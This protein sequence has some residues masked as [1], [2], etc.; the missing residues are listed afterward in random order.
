MKICLNALAAVFL[1]LFSAL[2][3]W[4]QEMDKEIVIENDTLPYLR[5]HE[6]IVDF[7][8]V[9][10]GDTVAQRY[11]FTNTGVE[12]LIIYRALTTCGCTAS[13]YTK[14]KVMPGE[15]GFVNVVFNTEGK[16]GRH[17]KVVTIYSNA[18]NDMAYIKLRGSVQPRE[19]KNSN[20]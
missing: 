1:L 13:E 15:E 8:E 4:A 5:F 11:T 17:N 6:D 12:P 20:P 16:T 14:S 9:T 19:M 3:A 10:E 7:G 2:N 18:Y